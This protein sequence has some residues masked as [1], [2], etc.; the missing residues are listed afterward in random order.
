M[1]VDQNV[2]QQLATLVAVVYI[3]IIAVAILLVPPL[4]QGYNR[5]FL[6]LIGLQ[7]KAILKF[8]SAYCMLFFVV[9]FF[10]DFVGVYFSDWYQTTGLALLSL[11]FVVSLAYFGIR[12]LVNSRKK[13]KEEPIV[14]LMPTVPL[15]Y[16]MSLDMIVLCV[17]FCLVALLGVS[18]TMLNLG[19]SNNSQDSYNWGRWFLENGILFFIIGA[20]NFV[21]TYIYQIGDSKK[22]VVK[23]PMNKV[24]IWG[25]VIIIALAVSGL[26]LS[27]RPMSREIRKDHSNLVSY[28]FA[29]PLT[30]T[31]TC[32]YNLDNLIVTNTSNFDWQNITFAINDTGLSSGYFY[33]LNTLPAGKSL[34][35]SLNEFAKTDGTRFNLITTKPLTIQIEV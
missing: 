21:L 9:L 22:Q 24:F 8:T 1:P 25:F 19:T 31:L 11:I 14:E 4:W 15:L 7:K 20:V 29:A 34:S 2:T 35:I 3:A 27:Y 30:I 18:Q 28:F 5:T 6:N 16:V 13:E 26:A 12:A 33:H 32:E 23:K 17:F 10:T